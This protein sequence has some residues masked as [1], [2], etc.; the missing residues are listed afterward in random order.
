MN[1]P[2]LN[3][4]SE[5]IHNPPHLATPQELAQCISEVYGVSTAAVL[6]HFADGVSVDKLVL[7]LDYRKVIGWPLD[8]II[9]HM[10]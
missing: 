4:L 1:Q 6:R 10:A 8:K 2:L 3:R 9:T 5:F 7:A